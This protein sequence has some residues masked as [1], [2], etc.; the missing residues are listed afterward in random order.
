MSDIVNVA[1]KKYLLQLQL[2]PLRT[3]AITAAFLAGFSDGVAQ[4]IAGA[5]RLQ[6]RRIL[7]F[8]VCPHFT[9]YGSS[10]S[11]NMRNKYFD[12]IYRS[13]VDP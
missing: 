9:L 12:S 5:K 11:L 10:D 4:K 8:M 1:W 2:H 3:K 13:G 7:L 6:L